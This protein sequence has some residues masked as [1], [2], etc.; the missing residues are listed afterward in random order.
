MTAQ[1]LVIRDWVPE[2]VS[3]GAHGH[4]SARWRKLTNAQEAA[5]VSA[6]N[7][8]WRPVR[9]PARLTITFVFPVA[10]HR[11]QD[12]LYARAKGLVDGL[13]KGG[14]IAD[15]RLGLLDLIVQADVRRGVRQT[16]LLLEEAG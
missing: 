8:G 10:R 12:N 14:Y 5:V 9:G 11:D 1:R 2:Q 3:N 13:V 15:D 6:R 7:R 16:E 4:W